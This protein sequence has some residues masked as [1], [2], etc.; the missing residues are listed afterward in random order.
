LS[1]AAYTLNGE[2]LPTSNFPSDQTLKKL[3]TK[4]LT[5]SSKTK[6]ERIKVA[7][8]FTYGGAAGDY[9]F[10]SKASYDDR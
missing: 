2:F 7:E 6:T 5:E 4:I 1:N 10:I 9:Y 8:T 3:L